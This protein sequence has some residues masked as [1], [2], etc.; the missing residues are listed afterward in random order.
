MKDKFYLCSHTHWDREWYGEYQQFRMR[1]VKM[2]D[3]LLEIFAKDPSYKCFNFDGQTIILEDYLEIRPENEGLLKKYIQEGRLVVGPWYMLPDEFLVTGESTV[4]N[5]QFGSRVGARLG[6]LSNVGYLPD[7]FGHFSQ[8]PQILSQWGI[9]M[10]ILWRGLS[11][12]EYKNELLWEAPDGSRVV[13]SKIPEEIGYCT[14]ALFVRSIVQLKQSELQEKGLHDNDIAS[15]DDAVDAILG[16]CARIKKTA[17]TDTH[18][19]FNG[20]DHKAANPEIPEIIRKAN[21]RLEDGEIVHASFDEYAQALLEAVEGKNLQVVRGE[22]RDTIHTKTGE[23]IILNGVLSSRIYNKQQNQECCTLLENWAEPFSVFNSLLGGRYEKGFIDKAWQWVLKNHPH[24]S[25][26]GCSI[27]AVHRQMETRF[28][29][30]REIAE[31]L[32]SFTFTDILE[33]VKIE[34]LEEW[35]YAFAVFNP[36][37]E[38]RSGWIQAEIEIPWSIEKHAPEGPFRGVVVTDME[39]AEQKVWLVKY[40]KKVVNRPSLRTFATAFRSPV[41]TVS[42]WAEDVPACGY[43]LLKFRPVEKPNCTFGTLSPERNVLENE[44]LRAEIQPNGTVVL[45][46][47]NTGQTYTKLHYFEDGGDNGGGYAYSFPK[48]DEVYTTLSGNAEVALVENS[49]A[50]AAYKV[51]TTMNLPESLD[52]SNQARSDRKVPLTIESTISLGYGSKRLDIETRV[53]NTVKDHR[54]RVLFPTYLN[55]NVSSGEAQFDVTDHPVFIEQPS[56]EIWKE[57]Q[58][59]QFAQKTFV[60]ITDGRKSLTVANI[61]LPEYEVTADAERAIAVTLVRAVEYLSTDWKNTRMGFGGHLIPT[62][63]AQ[64]MGRELVFR[65]SIIP[66]AG[67]W[68]ESNVQKE[69]HSFV[70]GMKTFPVLYAKEDAKLPTEHSFLSMEGENIA[71]SSV[72]GAEDGKGYIIRLWNGSES[73]S[74]AKIIL[75]K[76]PEKVYLSNI[77]EERLEEL[78]A[79]KELEVPMGAKKIVTLRV[80]KRC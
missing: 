58:P 8:M 4:R 64:M 37:P 74:V 51:V 43:K 66:H 15:G 57:D 40:E 46:D 45:V 48:D 50:R 22:L 70:Q 72:K 69:A 54:L 6:R 79:Y 21:E 65:Y 76:E 19:L 17:L 56:L 71:L 27:D 23:G 9:R 62:P 60:S 39:G 18:I 47:K 5:L 12:D 28:A 49:E 25:I 75:A 3:G 80:E 29:W 44:Y 24:D 67:A 53:V 42:L 63:D 61:G 68:S 36:R 14:A 2:L 55:A 11:G 32:L 35:E 31:N 16:A 59:K 26:G 10:A 77:K 34:G 38:K 33:N 1:L 20:V 73:D 78:P 30:A 41:F 13:L 7:T 52:S